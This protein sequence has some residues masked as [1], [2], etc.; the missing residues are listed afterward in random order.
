MTSIVDIFYYI[1]IY[2]FLFYSIF[3]L[4]TFFTNKRRFFADPKPRKYPSVS[5]IL[6]AFNEEKN[7]AKAIKSVLSQNYPKNKLKVI[8]VDDGSTDKTV[9]IASKFKNVT[10]IR[11]KHGG[12]KSAALN[13]GLKYVNT[14]L[15]GFMDADSY[16]TK[17]SIMHMVSYLEDKSV[18]AVTGTVRVANP[19]NILQRVQH[20]EYL[21]FMITKRVFH[22]VDGNYVT[23]AF[24]VYRTKELRKIGS[25]EENNPAEDIEIALRYLSKG[26]KIKNSYKGLVYTDTPSTIRGLAKQRIRWS[27]G[28]FTNTRKYSHLILN[29]KHGDLGMFSLPVGYLNLILV[30]IFIGLLLFGV[31]TGIATNVAYYQA[32]GFDFSDM[33]R[34]SFDTS[35]LSD[36]K[37]YFLAGSALLTLVVVLIARSKIKTKRVAKIKDYAFFLLVYPLITNVLL[38]IAFIQYIMKSKSGW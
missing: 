27:R 34:K 6:P 38:I 29:S 24:A 15:V 20:I 2:F 36:Y 33:F 37:T 4:L 18:G 7:I 19:K 30:N 3:Y 21:I 23:P 12:F 5:I 22:F 16:L 35:F 1:L 28:F 11:K 13:A 25:F 32:I 17:N 8:V 26:Y 10:V 31:Y 14:E 9:E